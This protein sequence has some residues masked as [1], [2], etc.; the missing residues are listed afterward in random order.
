[1][2]W[3]PFARWR[4]LSFCHGLALTQRAFTCVGVCTNVV[5]NKKFDDSFPTTASV[6]L[7]GEETLLANTALSFAVPVTDPS[8][9][10]G[11]RIGELCR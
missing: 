7:D 2:Q 1:M 11:Y 3:A 5:L 4:A 9:L 10:L 8:A 6:R